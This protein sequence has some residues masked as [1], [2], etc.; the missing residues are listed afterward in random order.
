MTD[1]PSPLV[2]A[3]ANER[4]LSCPFCG[5]GQSMVD[6]Y[7]DD[8]SKRW[9]VGCGRCGCST[10]IHPRETGPEPAIA[11]WNKRGE[12]AWQTMDTEPNDGA[13]RL[14]GLFVTNNQTG[15]TWFEVHYVALDYEGLKHPSG[16]NFDDWGFDD[17]VC[18]A[19]APPPMEEGKP[20]GHDDT[21]RGNSQ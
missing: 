18:W 15:F 4:L 11:A 19:P 5:P 8:M 1:T 10:G 2:S 21:K 3:N 13:F 12:I 14:Y 7:F 17:F 6:A 20:T 16:D 9:R